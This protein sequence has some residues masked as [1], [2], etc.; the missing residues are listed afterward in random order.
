MLEESPAA[1]T[2]QPLGVEGGNRPS[3]PWVPLGQTGRT[4]TAS[5]SVTRLAQSR[6]LPIDIHLQILA[7]LIHPYRT[8]AKIAW[9]ALQPASDRAHP[10]DRRKDSIVLASAAGPFFLEPVVAGRL[11]L[12]HSV[13]PF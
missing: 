1:A 3:P 10:C 2:L 13:P 4:I 8:Y 11:L 12:Q 9:N 6:F 5:D 7:K